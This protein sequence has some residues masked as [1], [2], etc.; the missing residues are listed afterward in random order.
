MYEPN[1]NPLNLKEIDYKR[2]N[3]D[4]I[5]VTTMMLDDCETVCTICKASIY[6]SLVHL[7]NVLD[8]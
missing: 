3:E 8:S 4:T 2:D 5:I 1:L 7:P 6:L